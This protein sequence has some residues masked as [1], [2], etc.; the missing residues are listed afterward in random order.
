MRWL[1]EKKKQ[2]APEC[3]LQTRSAFTE[4]FMVI[5]G[6]SKL[7]RMDLIF[8]DAGVKINGAFYREVLPTQKLL[9]IMREICGEFIII[10]I[11]LFQQGNALCSLKARDNQPSRTRDTCV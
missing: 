7:G 1:R 4:L 10:I 8:I 2:V 9:P 3:L 6:V 5:M 11:Y